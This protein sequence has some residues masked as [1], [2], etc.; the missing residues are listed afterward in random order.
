MGSGSAGIRSQ[1]DRPKVV[2]TV[3]MYCLFLYGFKDLLSC[4]I[5]GK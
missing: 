1:A 4:K 3:L 5:M 2:L